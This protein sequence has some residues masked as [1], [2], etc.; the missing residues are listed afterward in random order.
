MSR[1]YPVCPREGHRGDWPR[2]APGLDRFT[3]GSGW[4][5]PGILADG[6]DCGYRLGPAL[7]PV[8][9]EDPAVLAAARERILD[10]LTG[11]DPPPLEI[12]LRDVVSDDDAA[13][14]AW[15]VA[16]LIRSMR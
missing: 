11:G 4:E 10:F 16:G 1:A 5:C 7:Q 3:D 15:A 14:C 12:A 13:D 6:S 9:A 8:P 2:G